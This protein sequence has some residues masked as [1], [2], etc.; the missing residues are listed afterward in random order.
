[1][2]IL[3]KIFMTAAVILSFGLFAACNSEIKPEEKEVVA[4]YVGNGLM[5]NEKIEFYKDGSF[6]VFNEIVDDSKEVLMLVDLYKGNYEGKPAEDGSLKIQIT[7]ITDVAEL[8]EECM[9]EYFKSAID[10]ESSAMSK[11]MEL[12]SKISAQIVS[13]GEN[14]K[15]PLKY[16]VKWSDF[17]GAK[18]TCDVI[19]GKLT[20]F[21]IDFA[22][23]GSEAEKEL[24]SGNPEITPPADDNDDDPVVPPADDND[25]DPVVPPAD[26]T[27]DDDPVNPPADDPVEDP[28]DS[29]K[30]KEIASRFLGVDDIGNVFIEL[31]TDGSFLAYDIV[32]FGNGAT[33]LFDLYKGTYTGK[34]DED[35]TIH[36]SIT[37]RAKLLDNN[38]I[39]QFDLMEKQ[40]MEAGENPIYPVKYKDTWNEIYQAA[41]VVVKNGK[42]NVLNCDVAREDVPNDLPL[43]LSAVCSVPVDTV[44]LSDGNWTMRMITDQDHLFTPLKAEER[45]MLLNNFSGSDKNAVEALITKNLD[46]DDY[47]IIVPGEKMVQA[48]TYKL[49]LK[50][51]KVSATTDV[52]GYSVITVKET[53]HKDIIDYMANNFK[54]ILYEWNG[55]TGTCI[56]ILS[57]E[58]LTNAV[59]MGQYM[60]EQALE[61][62]NWKSNTDGSKYFSLDGDTTIY[63]EKK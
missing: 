4:T 17:N 62:D 23:V 41:A 37:H 19:K 14:A 18:K 22:R 35:G 48:A 15:L 10:A 55:N 3:K 28:A 36:F 9:V 52:S 1:M 34:A 16:D 26:D 59:V 61:Q 60:L 33:M 38:F 20:A 40:F 45:D 50:D 24:N 8:L 6:L 43:F 58:E 39:T 57:D 63:L 49:V 46:D 25:D 51:K 47:Y 7:G 42:T 30:P 44:E 5:G 2:D 29:E 27:G 32:D 13:A 54:N 56:Q 11:L 21:N 31:Y 12:E 53:L